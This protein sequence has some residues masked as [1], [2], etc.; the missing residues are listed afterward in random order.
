MRSRFLAWLF[1]EPHPAATVM[2]T[3][4]Q[5]RRVDLVLIKEE[6]FLSAIL[7]A[8][9]PGFQFDAFLEFCYLSDYFT[10]PGA[11]IFGGDPTKGRKK[12][13][14][15]VEKIDRHLDVAACRLGYVIVFEKCS[16]RFTDA[17]TAAAEKKHG[18]R[19][20]FIRGY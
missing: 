11:R 16:W 20:R 2:S 13:E 18:C 10:V 4:P 17:F 5:R 7:P 3:H 15:D 6:D 19:V 9:S 12:V 1:E 8:R 14:K